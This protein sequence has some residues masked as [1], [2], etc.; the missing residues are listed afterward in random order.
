MS[1]I[2]SGESTSSYPFELLV[3]QRLDPEEALQRSRSFLANMRRRRSIRA[4]S[5]EA[6]PL[7]LI[8]NAIAA[9][10]TAPS[11]AKQQPWHFVVV[12]DPQMK[13]RMREIVEQEERENY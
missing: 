6:V 1:E 3:F 9:A 7:E 8:E 5:P 11:G 4:F 13:R 12:S 10:A 2:T